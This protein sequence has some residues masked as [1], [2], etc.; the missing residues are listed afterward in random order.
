MIIEAYDHRGH[1]Y[2]GRW[3]V[4]VG[5]CEAADKHFRRGCRSFATW[6][7]LMKEL[8]MLRVEEVNLIVDTDLIGVADLRTMT[9]RLTVLGIKVLSADWIKKADVSEFLSKEYSHAD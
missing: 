6:T 1:G 2:A 5:L 9:E 7:Y 4:R 3:V 8:Q